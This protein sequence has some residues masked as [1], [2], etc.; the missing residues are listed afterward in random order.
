MH[1]IVVQR[2]SEARRS[3]KPPT[4][5]YVVGSHESR[6]HQPFLDGCRM[7]LADGANPDDIAVMVWSDGVESLQGPVGIAAGLAAKEDPD[8]SPR[9]KVW[10]EFTRHDLEATDEDG[11]SA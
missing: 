7:L 11:S 8:G 9:F 1:R 3:I 10:T 5:A 2:G 4:Y 6:S